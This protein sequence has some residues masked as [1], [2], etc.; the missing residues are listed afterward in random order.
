MKKF[1]ARYE[2]L[3][4][5]IERNYRLYMNALRE[6]DSE[7]LFYPD[8]NFTMRLTYGKA[9]GYRPTDAIVYHYHTT[10][11]GKLEKF[12]TGDEDY[13]LPEKLIQLHENKD[14]GR[15]ADTSG[16]MHICFIASNHT[17]GGNSGSPVM[18]SYGHLVGLNFDR[19]WE[20]TMSDIMYD[21][22]QC[23]NISV[24]IRYVLF[25]I[26]KFAD[27]GYLIDELVLV[28]D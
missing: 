27:A 17:S 2:F 22:S 11:S 18:N 13:D 9:E 7:R 1:F 19:N 3:S 12:T 8:A 15:W 24:D 10:L 26:E 14:Y 20:G 4:D 25:I 6:K 28:E 16:E 21:P 23:R 5:E